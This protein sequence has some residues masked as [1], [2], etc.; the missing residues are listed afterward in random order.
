M[1]VFLCHCHTVLIIIALKYSLKSGNVSL[2]FSRFLQL[3][4]IFLQLHTIVIIFS[5]SVKCFWHPDRDYTEF[6]DYLGQYEHFSNINSSN[7]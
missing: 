6:T 1:Y 2:S 3:F 7:Q 4:R 5:I